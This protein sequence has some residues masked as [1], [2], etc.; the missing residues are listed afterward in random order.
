MGPPLKWWTAMK[1]APVV[2]WE[3]KRAF[4]HLGAHHFLMPLLEHDYRET[5]PLTLYVASSALE[6]S[7]SLQGCLYHIL[8]WENSL[9]TAAWPQS[10]VTLP[11]FTFSAWST[12]TTMWSTALPDYH[13]ISDR[14]L[15]V[16]L[17][18]CQAPPH[19]ETSV[20]S[21]LFHGKYV[22]FIYVFTQTH[23]I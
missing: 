4:D 13:P 10:S 8:G 5:F 1:A 15:R 21:Y 20:R 17:G 11:R 2:C 7:R 12:P 19:P 23:P 6:P 3:T 18:K 9:H 22:Q 16:A 14:D